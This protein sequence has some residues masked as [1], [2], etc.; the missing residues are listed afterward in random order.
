MSRIDRIYLTEEL[1]SASRCWE[2]NVSNLTRNDHSRIGVDIVNAKAPE[3]GPGRWTMKADL[4]RNK[5]FMKEV[6]ALL[7]NTRRSMDQIEA[8][9]RTAEHNV[10]LVWQ[11]FK[12]RVRALAQKYTREAAGKRRSMLKEAVRDRD[13]ARD[14][15]ATAFTEQERDTARQALKKTEDRVYVLEEGEFESKFSYRR[16]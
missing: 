6:D 4:V 7:K 5:S 16:L 2:I 11:N 8:G 15:L 12:D 13:A 1:I 9:S 3:T 10:Q 14:S